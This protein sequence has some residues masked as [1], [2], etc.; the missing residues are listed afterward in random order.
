MARSNR[1]P[2]EGDDFDAAETKMVRRGR[3]RKNIDPLD[4]D[5]PE[6]NP[7]PVPS[8]SSSSLSTGKV[9][10]MIRTLAQS[11]A[12]AAWNTVM[13]LRP[14]NDEIDGPFQVF[15]RLPDGTTEWYGEYSPYDCDDNTIQE[16][17]AG[18]LSMR[19]ESAKPSVVAAGPT[20]NEDGD[21]IDNSLA[22]KKRKLTLANGS[23]IEVNVRPSLPVESESA[24]RARVEKEAQG[25][26]T[27][28]LMVER[29]DS[30]GWNGQ[31]YWLQ[32]GPNMVPK[33]VAD[34]YFESIKATRAAHV[35][36]NMAMRDDQAGAWIMAQRRGV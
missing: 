6:T 24:E 7:T 20:I 27:V 4:I 32:P 34:I 23:T 19:V 13:R 15:A 29:D 8:S 9:M 35:R 11:Q 3:P 36:M 12:Q 17:V 28:I 18:V 31:M 16:I 1:T 14:L 5:I 22:G 21:V 10:M 30:V 2:L 33:P 26:P 25:F